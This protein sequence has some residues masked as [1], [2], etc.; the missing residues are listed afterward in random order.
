MRRTLV[1]ACCAALFPACAAQAQSVAGWRGDGSGKYPDAAAPLHWGRAAKPVAELRA[2]ASKPKDG[3]AGTPMPDGVIREWLVL[4]PLPLAEGVKADDPLPD[5]KDASP[6]GGEQASGLA[7]RAVTFETNCLD[8]CG[9]FN[10]APD[11]KGVAAF[12]HAYLYSPSGGPVA[13]NFLFQGQ[14][15]SRVWLNGVEVCFSGKNVDL[16]PGARVALPLKKGW[17]RLLV[18]NSR[19]LANRKSWWV[20]CSLYG[21]KGAEYESRGILWMTPIQSSGSSAPVLAGDR[22]FLTSETGSV[23]CV[24]KID[25]TIR[26]V[27][28]LTYYDFATDE[29]R[30]AGAATFAE[31]DPLAAQL[32]QMEQSDVV[33]PWKPPALEKDWRWSIEGRII[34]AMARVS[35]E[36]Y[37]NPATWGCEA[38][39]TACMPVTDGQRVYALFGTGIVACY[40]LDGRRLWMRLLKRRMVEHGY[41]TS[42]LLVDGKLVIYFDS[43]T[44]LDAKTGAVLVERPHFPSR[45]GDLSWYHHFHGTGCVLDAGGE[46]VI[47]YLNGEFVRLRDG[48]TLGLSLEKL[49]A[50]KPQNWTE[51]GANRVATPVVEAGIAYKI[52]D[53]SGSVVAFRLPALDGDTVEPEIVREM[54]SNTDRFPYFYGA[55]YCASP[56]WYEGL[57]YCVNDFGVLTVL[58]AATGEV[59]YQR[60]LD[61]EIFMPYNGPGLLKG[62]ASSSPTLGGKRIYI[63]GNQ[64]TCV[65]LEP[66]RTFKPVARNR[67]ENF[68]PGWQA[69]QEATTTEPVF[70]GT[71]M[72]Y[73]GEYTLYCIGER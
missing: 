16:G 7:W 30:T 22:I 39:Y 65:V 32:K 5:L 28:T 21:D 53:G 50:L 8:F 38:G 27:R 11:R 25:G 48:K 57:L 68:I 35:Q 43:F 59:A 63:W 4:G 34:K 29:E 12:A 42:P 67:I 20:T 17:N 31:L 64:G 1:L 24:N 58:D 55:G 72:Y 69:H 33:M 70:E 51:G 52:L 66:G 44:V 49:A 37:N 47:Y 62:G 6:D 26:W 71:R 2:Q 56:L 36:R 23:F 15:T 46:K 61:L 10:V 40:D 54:P 41:T 9:L 73:R 45:P 14:G 19:T 13:F 18:L 60:L 3:D